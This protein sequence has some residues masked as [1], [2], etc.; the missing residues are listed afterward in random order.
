MAHPFSKIKAVLAGVILMAGAVSAAGDD[1]PLVLS[2]LDFADN[3][4]DENWSWLSAGLA[5]MLVTD[6]SATDLVMVDRSDLDE[7]LEEQKL[8]L[9]GI[10]DEGR[11]EIGRLLNAD[12]LLTGSYTISGGVMR[13]DFRVTDTTTGG[14]REAGSVSGASEALFVLENRLI[15]EICRVLEVSPPEVPAGPETTSL[16]AARAYYE[17]LVLQRSGAV[18]EARIRFEEAAELDPLYKKP[19]FSLEESW[20]LLNDFRK[21]RRQQEINALWRRAEALETRLAQNPFVT[22]TEAI[23][24]A[25][26]A[27]TPTVRTGSPPEEDPSL[28]SC[29]TP[30]VCLWNLQ[31]TWWEIGNL[32]REYF[33]DSETEEAT[34]GEVVRL[35]RLA[36]EQWPVDEWLPEILYWEVL[37]N[38]QLEEWEAVRTGCERIF[39]DWP[40]FRMGWALEDFYETALT[41]LGG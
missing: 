39:V 29:P 22:D 7:I 3:S 14:I 5:D 17:G 21:L 24:A 26:T 1:P 19:R 23:M 28:G 20:Q 25:Y 40:T 30:A 4:G 37:V 38:H 32:S 13:I 11:L 34:L 33:G 15:F 41:N 36:E 9:S 16:P 31:I 8:A 35:A 10:T 27:G 2:I 6:L 12:A 18:D